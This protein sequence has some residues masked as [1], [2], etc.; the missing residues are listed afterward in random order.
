LAAGLAAGVIAW[1]CGEAA[2]V[3]ETGIGSRGGNHPRLPAV[4]AARNA[5]VSFGILGAALGLGLGLAGGLIRRSVRSAVLAAT[6]GLVLGGGTGVG[7]TRLLLPLYYENLKAN[8]L[9]YS[10]IVHGGIWA[11]VGAAA[12]LA[13]GVGLGGRSRMIR[14][15]LGG[16]AAAGLATVIYEFAGSLLF[17]M[18]MTDRPLSRT[19]ETRLLARLLVAVLVAAG[20][21]LLEDRSAGEARRPAGTI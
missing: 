9:T 5:T 6:I 8:N 18:A 14:A 17:P 10:L 1:A 15:L 19:W 21:V 3:S 16:A 4:I 12:G 2:L 11:A 13:F 20:A 7:I